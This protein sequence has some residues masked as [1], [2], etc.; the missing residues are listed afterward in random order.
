[1][2]SLC[3]VFVITKIKIVPLQETLIRG[4]HSPREVGTDMLKCR[5]LQTY[6]Q[7]RISLPHKKE[8][9]FDDGKE[10]GLERQDLCARESLK[11][12]ESLQL[13]F[14]KSPSTSVTS[15]SGSMD[16][17]GRLSVNEV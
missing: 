7:S 11:F 1:M 12:S 17:R 14:K 2:Y 5:A 13:P 8:I 15:S 10:I 16:Y 3:I 4:T 6:N 9:S